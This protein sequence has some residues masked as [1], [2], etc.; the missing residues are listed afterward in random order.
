MHNRRDLCREA[1]VELDLSRLRLRLHQRVEQQPE[2]AQQQQCVC[3]CVYE[4]PHTQPLDH[5]FGGQVPKVIIL[6]D[7]G[8]IVHSLNN[9]VIVFLSQNLTPHL[10]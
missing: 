8:A 3:V 1:R 7:G 9:D 2:T 5:M 10:H 4:T 6:L